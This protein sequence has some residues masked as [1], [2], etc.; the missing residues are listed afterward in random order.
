VSRW[1]TKTSLIL[2]VGSPIHILVRSLFTQSSVRTYCID[3]PTNNISTKETLSDSTLHGRV[4]G[5]FR[6]HE[7]QDLGYCPTWT[8]AWCYK[9]E[10]LQSELKKNESC[11]KFRVTIEFLKAEQSKLSL[12]PDQTSRLIA[13]HHLLTLKQWGKEQMLG[14]SSFESVLRFNEWV[15]V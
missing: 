7:N 6:M 13:I 8:A 4:F 14:A 11:D 1:F 15:H 12:A 3:I 5:S 2:G 9:Q 10:M